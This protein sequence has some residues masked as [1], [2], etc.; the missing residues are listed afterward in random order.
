MPEGLSKLF[1]RETMNDSDEVYLFGT[2]G[3]VGGVIARELAKNTPYQI[4]PMARAQCELL[5]SEQVTKVFAKAQKPFQ[6]VMCSAVMR[7][8]GEPIRIFDEN[9]KMARNLV[10][11]LKDSSIENF[12][13][14]SSTD[15]YGR[16]PSE[17]PMRE[18]SP[19]RPTGNYGLSKQVSEDLF[20]LN[21]K[22][23]VSSLRLPGIYGPT[24]KGTSVIGNFMRKIKNGETLILDDGGH[25]RRDYFHAKSV[26]RVVEELIAKPQKTTL[27]LAMGK[28]I[29]LAELVA[30]I[31]EA[32]EVKARLEMRTSNQ[33]QYDFCFDTSLLQ[34]TL[35]GLEFISVRDGIR[36]Y[37]AHGLD[38]NRP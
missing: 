20:R 14:L 2:G 7:L 13:F 24:D 21:L 35:P 11:A 22:C 34:K 38:G 25:Q 1:L 4:T 36:D 33:K 6:V 23:P 8:P 27:N 12:I 29:T 30:M 5:D 31:E 28:A 19:V 17:V 3:F 37:A 9:V 16:P 32:L 15:V 10:E 26:A 18:S